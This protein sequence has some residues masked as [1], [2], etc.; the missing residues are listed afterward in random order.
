[1]PFLD[2]LRSLD[3]FYKF[4]T[5]CKADRTAKKGNFI[6]QHFGET[7]LTFAAPDEVRRE[8]CLT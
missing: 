3:V 6:A 2:P 8:F 4:K 5:N 7:K 1:M